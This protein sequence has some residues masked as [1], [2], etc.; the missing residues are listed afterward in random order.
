MT[1]GLTGGI[2]SGKSVVSKLLEI[3]GCA[4]FNSDEAAKDIYLNADV[5]EKVIALLGADSY[6][7][8]GG[9]ERRVISSKIFNDT[10]LLH[11]LN[12]IIHPAVKEKMRQFAE[13]HAGK[14]IVKET[15]LLFETHLD[16]EVDKIIVVTADEEQRV[17]R[18]MERD[19][20]SE[21][22]VLLRIKKQLPQEEKVE[23]ADFV[24]TNNEK[25]L[26]IPQVVK[27]YEK[28]KN[29]G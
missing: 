27:V 11:Q 24:I 21:A 28:L 5:K 8:K 2:G 19:G 15:A 14:I 10:L 6:N 26:L 17:K 18:V 1:I 16:K 25:E 20:L 29:L 3:M 23:R 13:L 7:E 4:V 9:I 22:D 12:G